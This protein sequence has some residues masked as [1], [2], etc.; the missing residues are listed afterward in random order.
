MY[1]VFF[2]D[3]FILLTDR[4]ELDAGVNGMLYFRYEDFEELHYTIEMLERES[5]LKA[6]VIYHDDLDVLWSDFRAHFKEVD[7]A[8]G[9]VINEQRQLLL[10]KRLGV[11]DLPKG[12]H[13]GDETSMQ[14][15]L[16]EVE[17]ECGI[18]DLRLN[19]FITS[20][21]HTYHHKGRFYLKK[22]DWYSMQSSQQELIPQLEE[23]IEE[24]HWRDLA[25]LDVAA[26]ETY[27]SIRLVISTFLDIPDRP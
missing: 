21:F 25:A 12:K 11:W 14:T 16:R 4:H 9:L 24:V 6:M 23:A 26:L 18:R 2:N 1:K 13:E 20:S 10:I 19:E 15:A 22:T 27:E 7:A 17:E 8:G 3:K 5:L